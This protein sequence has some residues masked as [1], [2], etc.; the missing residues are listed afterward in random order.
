MGFTPTFASMMVLDFLKR[1]K[2]NKIMQSITVRDL[3]DELNREDSGSTPVISDSMARKAL[4]TLFAFRYVALGVKI[5][6]S[7]TYYI[8]TEGLNYLEFATTGKQS[9]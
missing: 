8:T 5:G 2:Y 6:N 3:V 7:Y 9:K 4:D 1:N